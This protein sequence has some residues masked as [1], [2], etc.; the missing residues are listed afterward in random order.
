MSAPEHLTPG[1]AT[2]WAEIE[3]RWVGAGAEFVRIVSPDLEA[4]CEQA[5]IVRTTS[6]RVQA[7]G[8]IIADPKGAPVPHP[9]LEVGRKA[10]AELRAWGGRFDPPRRPR[11]P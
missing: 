6:A 9:A 11:R 5:A 1:A 4:Y 3:A 10:Q 2:V 7:E 8:P